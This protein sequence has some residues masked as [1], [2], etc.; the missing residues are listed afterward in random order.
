[1]KNSAE[2]EVYTK[3]ITVMRMLNYSL[4]I[5]DSINVDVKRDE[6]GNI[7]Y[8][9]FELLGK[10]FIRSS[11]YIFNNDIV[12]IYSQVI[13]HFNLSPNFQKALF[14]SNIFFVKKYYE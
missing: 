9:R 7:T 14:I 8:A 10:S 1:M 6:F 3:T 13:N 11:G 4:G 12:N 5:S 2:Q